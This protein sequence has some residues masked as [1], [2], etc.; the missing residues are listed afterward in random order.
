MDRVYQNCQPL[1][2]QLPFIRPVI[3]DSWRRSQRYGVDQNCNETALLSPSEIDNIL[4][5][6]QELIEVSHSYLLHLAEFIRGTNFVL[7]LT[8]QNGYVID[9]VVEDSGIKGLMRQTNLRI[10]SIRNEQ[11]TGTS[12]IAIC[13]ATG[14]PIQIWGEEHYIQSHH[15]Y[16]C[17]AAPIFDV[18]KNLWV[19]LL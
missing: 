17:S 4:D 8:D 19:V 16:F 2:Q 11:T 1:P 7:A 6:S 18:S 12:G 5:S 10:G 15:T 13:L 14:T 9:I 3:L